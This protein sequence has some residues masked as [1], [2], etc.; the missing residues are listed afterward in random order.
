MSGRRERRAGAAEVRM[1]KE[2]MHGSEQRQE[3]RPIRK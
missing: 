2:N 1:E 3:R